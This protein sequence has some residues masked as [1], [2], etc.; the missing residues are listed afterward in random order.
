MLLQSFLI[1]IM[2]MTD[3]CNYDCYFC[4]YA[5]NNL[6]SK[7][8][9]LEMCKHILEQFSKYNR[10]VS[11]SLMRI[12]FHGGEPL[13]LPVEYYEEVLEFE[14]WLEG[15][16]QI[17]YVHSIQTN[18]FNIDSKWATLFRNN[19][20]DVGISIDGPSSLND[21]FNNDLGREYC[22]NKVLDNIKLL[23]QESVSVGVISV[24][25][26]KH[27][28]KAEEMYSFCVENEIHDLSL[29]Y[30]YN[31]D[32]HDSVNVNGLITFLKHL[33][34]LYFEEE[35]PINIR[36]FNEIIAKIYG[37]ETDTCATCFRDNCGQYLSV[38]S[39]G[40]V[41]FCDSSYEKDSTLGNILDNS[42]FEITDSIQYIKKVLN[43][44]AYFYEH[45]KK[46]NMVKICGGGCYRFDSSTG[47]NYFC[48]ALFSV[49]Q[50]IEQRINH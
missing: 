49:C 14:K 4:H 3:S 45:C 43:A 50:Y 12:I 32:S 40:R 1:P 48:D 10:Y 2:K 6:C 13:L 36:E 25:T 39:S 15:K 30:C 44:R 21:H 41:F 22:T 5:Q 16:Y 11:N 33:F 46:C 34:D 18:G 38:D 24:I 37:Q 42:L 26:D 9:D 17:E 20:I 7:A 8:M 47:K 29:N 27:L 35:Y 28:S 19:A 23:N 31:E